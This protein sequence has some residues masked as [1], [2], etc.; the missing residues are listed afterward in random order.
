MP[1]PT[2]NA[3]LEL[4]ASVLP[5]NAYVRCPGFVE[6]YVRRG[7]RFVAG[8]WVQGVLDIARV[9][10]RHP[11]EGAFTKLSQEL[12]ERGI[13]LYVESVLNKRFIRK[14]EELGFTRVGEHE[15]V[16]NFFK[17]P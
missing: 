16:P 12:L 9:T 11:G 6:L 2:L 8:E 15:G 13:P 10:A 1:L 7:P 5:K 3:F 14:L 4:D 17:A